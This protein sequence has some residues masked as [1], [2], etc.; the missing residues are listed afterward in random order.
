MSNKKEKNQR[1]Q[2]IERLKA[3]KEAYLKEAKEY[4]ERIR[5]LVHFLRSNKLKFSHAQ[6][7]NE[8]VEYFRLD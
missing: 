6:I 1:E 8:R 7:G 3:E 2:T 5:P 4:K